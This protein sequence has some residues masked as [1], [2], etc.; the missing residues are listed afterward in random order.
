MS[1]AFV[2]V[3]NEI[4]ERK[5]HAALRDFMRR[6]PK[7]PQPGREKLT[8]AVF[9]YFR[10]L[11]WLEN[12]RLPEQIEAAAK[13]QER[14]NQDPRSVKDQA[15]AALA[16]PDWV[17]AELDLAID[18]AEAEAARARLASADPMLEVLGKP[19]TSAGLSG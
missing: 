17:W 4:R 6:H 19:L 1:M 14:F 16:V 15:L 12:G 7:F 2:P 11:R 8:R 9:A 10:W 13:I 3:L 18:P 5:D